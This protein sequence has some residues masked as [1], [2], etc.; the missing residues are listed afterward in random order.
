VRSAAARGR[1]YL[2]LHAG[3]R[4]QLGAILQES[5]SFKA[6]ASRAV[7]EYAFPFLEAGKVTLPSRSGPEPSRWIRITWVNGFSFALASGSLTKAKTAAG[8]API[9]TVAAIRMIAGCIGLALRSGS[10]RLLPLKNSIHP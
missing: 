2:H 1:P 4:R 6:N 7:L 8:G 5:I 9:S 3:Q 10:A